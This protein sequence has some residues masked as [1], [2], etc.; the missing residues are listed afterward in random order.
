MEGNRSPGTAG[1]VEPTAVIVGPH[2]RNKKL[3]DEVAKRSCRVSQYHS[4]KFA[5]FA[6][7][8]TPLRGG[9]YGPARYAI[10]FL[11]N[12]DSP[13]TSWGKFIPSDSTGARLER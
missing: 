8:G 11:S 12:Q 9:P 2:A 1:F 4:G 3:G 7:A 13:H 5:P 6:G 10:Q